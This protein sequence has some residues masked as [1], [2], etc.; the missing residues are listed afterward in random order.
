MANDDAVT[1]ST[2]DVARC[3]LAE[4]NAQ[5]VSTRHWEGELVHTRRDGSSI[6]VSSRWAM[7]L[8][9]LEHA[10]SVLEINTDITTRKQMEAMLREREAS[11]ETAQSLAHL[12]SWESDVKTNQT[13]WS[14]EAYRLL[15]YVEGEIRPS[16]DAYL[17]S[18]TTTTTLRS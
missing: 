4:I 13:Y 9:D 10:Q 7:Q 8:A 12:G 3:P 6:I 2:P 11:L 16:L 15:G 14:P 17:P 5:L 1:A 18:R